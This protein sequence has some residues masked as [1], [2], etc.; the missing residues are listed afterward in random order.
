MGK[1][2]TRGGRKGTGACRSLVAKVERSLC[3]QA[4]RTGVPLVAPRVQQKRRRSPSTGSST[5][6][7]SKGCARLQ[8]ELPRLG[9]AH[10]AAEDRKCE[11]ARH[12]AKTGEEG[13]RTH[14]LPE[15][16]VEI[17]RRVGEV[18]AEESRIASGSSS[19]STQRPWSSS[20]AEND[21][22]AA[23]DSA[24]AGRHAKSARHAATTNQSLHQTTE[25]SGRA[26]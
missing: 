12:R 23:A 13:P 22:R 5:L 14:F 24:V 15:V 7:E 26:K 8:Q 2:G 11:E 25:N 18:I 4:K 6:S 21:G 9:P 10:W 20:T 17:R 16:E 19:S 3:G 1:R